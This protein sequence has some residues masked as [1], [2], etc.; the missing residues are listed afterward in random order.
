MAT[1]AQVSTDL[2]GLTHDIKRKNHDVRLAVDHAMTEARKVPSTSIVSENPNLQVALCLPFITSLSSGN[3]KLVNHSL[4]VLLRLATLQSLH[5]DQ[6]LLVIDSLH[7]LDMPSQ[8]LETQLKIL[9]ASPPLT[10]NYSL[11]REHFL[12]VTAV[13][14][15]LASNTNV[16]VANTASATL[17]QVFSSLYDKLRNHGSTEEDARFTFVIDVEA[18]NEKVASFQ[19]DE[20]E[21]ECCYVLLDLSS[22]VDGGHMEY[23]DATDI[24]LRPQAALEIIETIVS[25][26]GDAFEAH[27]ELAALLK[28]KTVP[29]LLKVLNSQS[30]G[31]SMAVRT[32][33]ILHILVAFHMDM[34][35]VESEI[36]ISFANHIML[37]VSSSNASDLLLPYGSSSQN[38]LPYWEK[39]LILEFYKGLFSNFGT[40]RQIYDIYDSDAKKKNVLREVLSVLDIYLENNFSQF[41]SN[42]TIQVPQERTGNQ[43]SKLSSTLKVAVLDHL[44]KLDPPANIPSL[45]SVHLIFKLL[46]SFAEGV[47]DFVTNLSAN[48]NSDTLE[49]DV[50][51]VTSMN[52]EVFPEIFQLFKKYIYCTM[53][54]DYFHMCIRALQ[55]YTH[56][57]G[58]LGLSSLRDG[59]L[60][61]L[62]DCCIKNTPPDEVKKN[63][64]SHLLSIGESIVESLSSTIQSPAIV[65]PSLHL[66][67]Q[68][69]ERSSTAKSPADDTLLGLRTFN[70]RQ[71]VCLR[72]LS[73]L[74][75]SL[76]STIQNSWKIV[77]ITFQWVDYFMKG[78]DQFS[79]YPN[80]KDIKK[81]GEPKLSSQDISSLE[82]SKARFFESINEY[83]QTSF[84]ELVFVLAELYDGGSGNSSDKLIPLDTCPFNKTYFVD[85]LV[86]IA[87]LNPQKFLFNHEETWNLLID[88]FTTWG[89]NR[90]ITYSMRNYLVNSFTDVIVNVTKQGFLSRNEALDTILAEKSMNALLAFLKSLLALGRPQEH[91]VLNCETELHLTIL[92]TA[93]GLIDGYVERYQK[94][95]DLVFEILNTAF[96]NTQDSSN[97]NN[98]NAKIL[99]LISTSFGTLKLILDEFLTTLPTS[100]LKSLIDTLLNFCSQKY[101]LNI[102][103]SSVS[104]FWLISDCINTKIGEQRHDIS[105]TNFDSITSMVLLQ[106]LLASSSDSEIM[107]QAL[108][109]YLLAQLSNLSTDKRARVREGAIQTLFQIIDVQ[110]KQLPSWKMVYNIVL[111]GLLDLSMCY[112]IEEKESRKDAIESLNLVLSGLVSVYT[113]FMMNFDSGNSDLVLSF[114]KKLIQ[115]FE[116]MFQLNWKGL[117]LKI[118]QSYQDLILAL[119]QKHISQ[120]LSD[121]LFEF[122]VN[123]S[124]DYDFVK[125]EYQ[126]S[127]AV[128]NA[129]FKPLFLIVKDKLDFENA[130]RVLSNLNKC[131]RYPVLKPSLN[132]TSKPTDLQ[133]SVLDNLLLIDK[134]GQHEEILAGIIQQLGLISSYPYEIRGRIEAKLKNVEGK[135]K[136][137]SF[138]AISDMALEMLDLKLHELS[139]ISV[140]LADK[141]FDKLARSLLYL[142]HYKAEGIVGVNNEPLWVRCNE[143]IVYLVKRLMSESV[144]KVKNEKDVW[145]LLVECISV[146]FESLTESQEKHN[147]R[148]Y[149]QLTQS[150][151]PVLF[152]TQIDQGALVE[153]FVYNVYK[154]S[155]LYELN[156]VERD[157]VGDLL[158]SGSNDMES[159]YRVLADF[160]FEDSFG[161]TVQLPVYRNREIRL[162][163]LTELF[164][165]AS[166]SDRSS[167]IAMKCLITRSAFTLRRF[168]ASERLLLKRPLPKIQQ[169]EIYIILKGLQ[170]VQHRASASQMAGIYKLLSQAI[171]YVTR[172]E[173][174]SSLVEAILRNGCA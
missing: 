34:L 9:Q 62:S 172:L 115:Y 157:L 102:S 159:A 107:N 38:A 155:F 1:V 141:G 14:S 88:Y 2:A 48:A 94:S 86:I 79:G 71:V 122:W 74:A 43:L 130:S 100:Q 31:F 16:A 144:D 84:Q 75:L 145:N 120:E 108:N 171:P 90:A 7:S 30:Y 156:D 19:V 139:S 118:F 116:Q 126:D 161:T 129:S 44:D 131:A 60:L 52:E 133:K 143:L 132:D 164:S 124:I 45:Y 72:A 81:Y 117:N 69:S 41:F 125:P 28:F 24:N 57:I 167:L 166:S 13:C 17:Q 53:D 154:Q 36:V 78:P 27:A 56:A 67:S 147:V 128:Y 55:K 85:Q 29:A 127:L 163:C 35:E 114:W 6:V 32:L 64:A 50:E 61:T 4:L 151:L 77:W 65:S 37:N 73:N 142:V 96:I 11:D 89:T 59:L 49:T 66:I 51:F 169:E 26:N 165:F 137:P 95:W 93:H 8:G 123:V 23:F 87:E 99:S 12:R 20:L 104:Y 98:L 68:L 113:K 135:L 15:R 58:L 3:A 121:L 110:G 54:S 152:S 158:A 148:Q 82:A 146:C 103:F 33:R 70:S 168:T 106:S 112:D 80:L 40:V 25:L 153:E 21:L 92:K 149:E 83:Q 162:K 174:I 160:L 136:I 170:S 119:S 111:P 140:L 173:N 63:G 47:S 105:V 39:V 101:E 76:G 22:V 91:L 18:G 5:P 109:I 97:D 42:D 46:V 134:K 150:I 10:Q 138:I